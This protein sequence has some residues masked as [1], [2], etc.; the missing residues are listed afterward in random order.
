MEAKGTRL[1]YF[2]S[3]TPLAEH[4]K[5]LI[6]VT[7]TGDFRGATLPQNLMLRPNIVMALSEGIYTG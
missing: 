6:T 2:V 1:S 4:G 7:R 3:N 5:E